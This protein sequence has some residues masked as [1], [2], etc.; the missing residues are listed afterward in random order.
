MLNKKKARQ[1]EPVNAGSMA[2]IA[3]LLL[4][5]FLVTT[6]ILEDQGIY[7]KLP[8]WEEDIIIKDVNANNVLTVLVN[9]QDQLLVEGE[10][11]QIDR[12]RATTKEF[13]TNPQALL[14]R[15]TTPKNAIVSIMNDRSTTYETYIAVYNEIKGAYN[16]LW[17]EAARKAYGKT[18]GELPAAHQKSIRDEIPLVISEAEP[19]DHAPEQN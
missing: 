5:F 19:T 8:P 16:E 9:G 4:I 15:P 18:Y 3:F 2:D 10:L 11:L 12:L 17:N 13:I 1:S 6:T 14:N 7:V